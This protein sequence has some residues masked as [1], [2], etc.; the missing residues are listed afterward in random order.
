MC[1]RKSYVSKILHK[2]KVHQAKAKLPQGHTCLGLNDKRPLPCILYFQ[3]C[4]VNWF[5]NL[6][7]GGNL[8]PIYD[9]IPLGWFLSNLHISNFSIKIYDFYQIIP[10]GDLSFPYFATTA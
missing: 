9:F 7:L 6:P 8:A 10:P 5:Q 1:N 3:N 4:N 2:E